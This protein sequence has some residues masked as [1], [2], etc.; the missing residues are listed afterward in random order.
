MS[1]LAAPPEPVV[2]L[3]ASYPPFGLVLRC[4]ELT[5]RP[6]AEADMPAYFALL[7]TPIFEDPAA[8]HV[9]PWYDID[10][11]Q[12]LRQALRFQW[13][14]RAELGPE[15]WTLPFGVWTEDG[16]R[17]IGCQDLSA[18]GFA[19]RR[20]VSSGS[21][22]TRDQ[23]GRGFGGL[24]RRMLLVLAVDHLGAERAE[25][26][27]VLGNERSM[28]VSRS[29]GYRENGTLVTV[30]GERRV[31]QQCFVLDPADLDR[32]ERP[33]V[34]HGLTPALRELLGA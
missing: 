34:V 5:L 14:I 3:V 32:P 17:L 15:R 22:L 9:F 33:V 6:L 1:D 20:V 21:W 26:S 23:H 11:E 25:T 10:P 12:R 16:T 7:R 4:G 30:A 8:D 24:M 13:R 29:C 2:P 18:E 27:A 28:A 19:R 31:V